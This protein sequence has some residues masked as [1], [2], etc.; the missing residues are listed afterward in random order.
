[1]FILAK[2]ALYISSGAKAPL[3]YFII[4]QWQNY[5]WAAFVISLLFIHSIFELKIVWEKGFQQPEYRW[6]QLPSTVDGG[7]WMV[8]GR[9]LS[10]VHLIS[11]WSA[12]RW[13]RGSAKQLRSQILRTV[14]NLPSIRKKNII[15]LKKQ[16]MISFESWSWETS[17]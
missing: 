15:N 11:A 14:Y 3:L 10:K 9:R 8:S 5:P 6:E 13:K 1:M 16:T 12:L 4:L 17:T 7:W 2:A